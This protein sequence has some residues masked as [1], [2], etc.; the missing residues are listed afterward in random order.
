MASDNTYPAIKYNVNTMDRVSIHPPVPH[1]S[2]KN[3]AG[4]ADTKARLRGLEDRI[5][6]KA[7]G[8]MTFEQYLDRFMGAPEHI[9][10]IRGVPVERMATQL[11]H[12]K[13]QGWLLTVLGL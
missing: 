7:R 3:G 4:R 1:F 2:R 10:L 11:T 13:L 5:V 8:L 12:E 6:W 9:E